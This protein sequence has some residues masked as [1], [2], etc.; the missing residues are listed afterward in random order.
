MRKNEK[1]AKKAIFDDVITRSCDQLKS[2]LS[3]CL[4]SP[5]HYLQYVMLKSD[6]ALVVFSHE[7]VKVV[8]VVWVGIY[9]YLSIYLSIY[10]TQ[11]PSGATPKTILVTGEGVSFIM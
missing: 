5:K 9:I 8:M 3:T 2:N 1:I 11:N 10:Q 7:P 4:E 6:V